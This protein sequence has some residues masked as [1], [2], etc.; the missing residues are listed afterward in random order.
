[1]TR[2][3]GRN[4]SVVG[5]VCTERH[6]GVKSGMIRLEI[7]FKQSPDRGTI[8][9]RSGHDQAA[10]R[11]RSGVDRGPRS[12]STAVGSGWSDSAM[13]DVRSRFDRAA[14]AARSRLDR[15]AIIGFFHDLSALSD[16]DQI[17]MKITT[18]RCRSMFPTC[19]R[20]ASNHEGSRLSTPHPTTC[21][22]I[23]K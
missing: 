21:K 9:P 8:G 18:V 13:K 12:R 7:R 5:A 15:T 20:D 22:K 1:M 14:I 23:N 6:C 17:V 4:Q 3:W 10:I 11:P 19:P 2:L 16:V